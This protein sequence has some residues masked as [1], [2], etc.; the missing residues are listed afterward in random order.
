MQQGM[1]EL[2]EG[3]EEFADFNPRELH[4]IEALRTLRL[5]HH[6]GWLAKRW[7]DPAFPRGFPWFNTDKFWQE[8]ILNLKEQSS[9]MDEPPINITRNY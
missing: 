1:L 4:L 9:L 7:E 2:V 5:V 3:Y 6:A 8:H